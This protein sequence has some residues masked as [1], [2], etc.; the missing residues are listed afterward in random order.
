MANNGWYGHVCAAV[1]H[2]GIII[3]LS[4]AVV[5]VPMAAVEEPVPE[6]QQIEIGQQ[7]VTPPESSPVEPQLEATPPVGAEV[8]VIDEPKDTKPSDDPSLLPPMLE[9]LPKP[10]EMLDEATK[11][12]PG[13]PLR[14]ATPMDRSI[15]KGDES[16][17]ISE[18]F[19]VPLE[20][21]TLF[22]VDLSG[23]M[24]DA[25][26][27]ITRGEAV[28][29]ELLNAIQSLRDEDSFDIIAYSGAYASSP[30]Y[31][32]HLWGSLQGATD[33][34]KADA[35]RWLATLVPD[36]G[37]P[38]YEALTHVCM[39]YPAS[40]SNLILVTDGVPNGGTEPKIL[41]SIQRLLS[42]FTDLDFICISISSA[43][44]DFVKRL[45][46][47]AGGTYVLVE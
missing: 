36:S 28:V 8:K 24:A 37:T 9:D 25:Y 3:V 6:P 21:D 40:V 2:A 33:S 31:T 13:D 5:R 35:I 10:L 26:G 23:S 47:K 14:E 19:G 11:G 20:G 27:D 39:H 16:R 32:K 7:E 41:G 42:R 44:L 1:A 43:G 29:N 46:D 18:M 38:T 4:I 22:L 45:V 30:Y 34:N 12:L 17:G 15:L